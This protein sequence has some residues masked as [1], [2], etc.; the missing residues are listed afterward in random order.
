MVTLPRL[1]NLLILCLVLM[2]S[3]CAAGGGA[4]HYLLWQRLDQDASAQPG[5]SWFAAHD[6]VESRCF[7]FRCH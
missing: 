3:G 6:R 2:L 7:P 4:G 1:I 5:G